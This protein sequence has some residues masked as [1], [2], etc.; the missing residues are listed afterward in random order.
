[1]EGLVVERERTNCNK[2]RGAD[3]KKAIKKSVML[4]YFLI[5]INFIYR[6]FILNN[7]FILNYR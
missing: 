7:K 4:V 3:I 2:I 1:M 5:S 6:A